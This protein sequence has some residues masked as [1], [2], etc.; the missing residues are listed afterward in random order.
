MAAQ[1]HIE[2]QNCKTIG[3]VGKI[4]EALKKGETRSMLE[5]L[6]AVDSFNVL[7]YLTVTK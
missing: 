3:Q 2:G 4:F 5:I 6:V 7:F 1:A